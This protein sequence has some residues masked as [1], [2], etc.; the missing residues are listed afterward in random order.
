MDKDGTDKRLAELKAERQRLGSELDL[1]R[2]EA[3]EALIDGKRP[4]N[5]AAALAERIF[6]VDDAIAELSNRL[7]AA[8]ESAERNNRKR[9]AEAAL[10]ATSKR[11]KLAASVDEAL[12]AL[13]SN[14]NAY[15]EALRKDVGQVSGAGGDLTAVERALT[16][17]R[18]A[19]PLVKAL[20][21]A[22]GVSFARSLGIDTPIRERHATPLTDAEGRVAE[23]LRAELLRIKASSPQPNV[24]REAK[25]E[26]NQME[27]NL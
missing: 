8:A 19:E 9:R 12:V 23:S 27:T 11:T 10:D 4:S 24:S 14:W 25:A 20:I 18:S 2:N 15:A 13:A 26:L 3:R 6:I 21:A 16:N 17:N 5:S 7:G 22:G 1:A